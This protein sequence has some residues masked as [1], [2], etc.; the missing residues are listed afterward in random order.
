MKFIT[1]SG[2]LYQV[3]TVNKKIRRLNGKN[4]PTPRQGEDGVFKSYEGFGSI[5]EI[6]AGNDGKLTVGEPA[7][8]V[9]IQSEHASLSDEGGVKTT[10]TSDVV[11][12]IED[13]DENQ[14][15]S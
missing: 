4:D 8:I 3:D 6:L 1:L 12:I 9:W 14:V 11:E 2:S 15:Q 10:L 5:K 13:E 7:L